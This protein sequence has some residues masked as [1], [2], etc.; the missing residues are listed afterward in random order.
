MVPVKTTSMEESESMESSNFAREESS[1]TL[2]A[3]IQIRVTFS[4]W[5]E[6]LASGQHGRGTYFRNHLSSACGRRSRGEPKSPVTEEG[7]DK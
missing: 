1:P 5:E 2:T 6:G 3:W 4:F 7:T